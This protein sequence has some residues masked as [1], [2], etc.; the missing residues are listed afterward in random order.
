M[1]LHVGHKHFPLK[2]ILPDGLYMAKTC[3]RFSIAPTMRGRNRKM[4]VYNI[5]GGLDPSLMSTTCSI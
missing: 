2:Q 3:I 4:N 1:V 5:Y